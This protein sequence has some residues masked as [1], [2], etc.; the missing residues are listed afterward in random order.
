MGGWTL[1][2]QHKIRLLWLQD[3]NHLNFS[4]NMQ[5]NIIIIPTKTLFIL[6]V[7]KLIVCQIV[8]TQIEPH[9]IQVLIKVSTPLLIIDNAMSQTESHHLIEIVYLSY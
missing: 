1:C 3:F 6:D 7:A 9:I 4:T 5:K 2:S 8:E